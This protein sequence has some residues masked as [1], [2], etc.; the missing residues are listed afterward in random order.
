METL[1]SVVIPIFNRPKELA[2]ALNSLVAQDYQNFEVIIV[3]D[4]STIDISA[5]IS[6]YAELLQLTCIKISNSGGPARPRNIGIQHA[7]SKWIALLDSDDWWHPTKIRGVTNAI[8]SFPDV[9]LFYHRLKIISNSLRQKWWQARLLG[10]NISGDPFFSLMVN[11]NSIPNSSVVF[12]RSCFLKYGP[13]NE[14]KNYQSVEDFDYWL[15]LAYSRCK[16]FFI[17]KVLGY[18]SLEGEGISSNFRKTIIRNKLLLNKYINFLEVDKRSSAL[19]RYQYFA[20]SVLY[21]AGLPGKAHY[22]LLRAKNLNQ[23]TFR[24]KRLYK[25]TRIYLKV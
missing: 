19:S 16:F 17:P 4:G 3:D 25:L 23:I 22:Y 24:L 13:L 18:Y 2:R 12:K 11:G 20:G 21:S 7:Q 6:Q 10:A 15:T 1:I 8:N 14:A 9:D 5:V